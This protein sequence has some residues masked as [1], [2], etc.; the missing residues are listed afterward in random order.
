MDALNLPITEERKMK[1]VTLSSRQRVLLHRLLHRDLRKCSGGAL[2]AF[3]RFGWA[4]GA[5]GGF[6]LTEQ[7][8]RIAEF[9][10]LSP[11]GGDLVL[12]LP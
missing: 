12:N 9:S 5:S 11:A 8:R 4:L 6:Q 3:R 1:V 2:E 10:E 7:G